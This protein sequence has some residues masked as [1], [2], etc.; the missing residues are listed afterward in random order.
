LFGLFCG[1]VVSHDGAAFHDE[2][3]GFEDTHITERITADGD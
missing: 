2:F 3:D 1:E